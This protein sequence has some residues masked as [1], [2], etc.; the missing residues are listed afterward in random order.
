[1]Q[2]AFTSCSAA[3]RQPE[4]LQ[5]QFRLVS[6]LITEMTSLAVLAYVMSTQGRNCKEIGWNPEILDVPRGF[7]LFLGANLL[8]YALLIPVQY[9]YRAYAGHFFVPKSLNSI[10]GFGVSSLSIAFICLNPFFEELIVRAFTIS[11]AINLGASR[12]VAITL[13][14]VVQVSYH[15]YQGLASALA[16][17]LV[18]T[19]FSI[20]YVRTRRIMPVIVAH[21]CADLFALMLGRF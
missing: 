14:V 3:P 17:T 12:A 15:L 10:F 8:M 18:F 20:Y 1:L 4:I 6:A 21:L 9:A 5:K 13:S 7:G 11:E 2:G 16:L 19:I